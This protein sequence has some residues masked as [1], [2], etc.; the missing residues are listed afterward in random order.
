[1]TAAEVTIRKMTGDDVRHIVDID[2]RIT[3]KDRAASWP[4]TVSRYLE[5]YY[6]PLCQ[7]AEVGGQV[8]GFVLG[9][10]RGWEYGMPP[11]GWI[12]IMGV[13]PRFHRRGI[14]LKLIQAFVQ[15]CRRLNM[16]THIAVRRQDEWLQKFILASG[17][18]PGQLIEF[19]M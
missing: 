13:D 19:E 9:D 18:Q 4:Q 11:G 10:V 17:F 7:V 3:G 15:E 2:R 16:K 1:M 14:G 12:D 5:M 8:V 6:P